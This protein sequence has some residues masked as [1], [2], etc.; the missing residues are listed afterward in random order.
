M[1]STM[2]GASASAAYTG[3]GGGAA[4]GGAGSTAMFH[5]PLTHFDFGYVHGTDGDFNPSSFM[6][7]DDAVKFGRAVIEAQSK[8]K[9]LGE[10]AAENRSKKKQSS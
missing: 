9:T 6:E 2:G 8:P 5:T 4:G 10:I 3:G 1:H 7:Y